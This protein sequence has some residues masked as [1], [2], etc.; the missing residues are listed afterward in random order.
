MPAIPERISRFIDNLE[1]SGTDSESKLK[2][3]IE[4]E[5]RRRLNRYYLIDRLLKKKYKMR[6]E[7][8]DY[9][10]DA[11]SDFCDWEMAITGIECL[12]EDLAELSGTNR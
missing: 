1:E 2:K 5:Y 3:I 6:F 8:F 9:S 11:E 10:L 7:E 4:N 12:Q